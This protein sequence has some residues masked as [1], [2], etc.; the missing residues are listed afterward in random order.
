MKRMKCLLIFI[1]GIYMC[2][3]LTA[4]AIASAHE[5]L[6]FTTKNT[7]SMNMTPFYWMVGIVGGSIAIT[8]SY[9]GWRK[10]RAEKNRQSEDDSNN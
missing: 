1:I 7:P 6:I 4:P 10:Y 3:L 2:T 9:V 5:P 8:L